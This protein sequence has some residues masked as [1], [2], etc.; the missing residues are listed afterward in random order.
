[1]EAGT[2]KGTGAWTVARM[3]AGVQVEAGEVEQLEEPWKSAAQALQSANGSGRINVLRAFCA[4]RADGDEL[5]RTVLEQDPRKKPKEKRSVGL[6]PPLPAAASLP[7]GAGAGAGMWLDEYTRYAKA[8]SPLTPELFHEAGGLW[9]VSLAVARR[10]VLHMSHK[11]VFPNVAILQVAPTTLY[12]KS[13]GLGVPRFI[14]GAVMPYLLLPGE[15]TP[16]AMVEELAGKT[17]TVL[18]GLDIEEWQKGQAYAGQRGIVL[19]EASSLFAGLGKDYQV[20]MGETL[21]RLYD[22]DPHIARQTRG[23][24]RATVRNAYWTFLGATTPWHL[25]KADC[26]SLWHTGI[27]ARF[28]LLTPDQG[29]SWHLPSRMRTEVPSGLVERIS[30]LVGVELPESKHLDP[31][32]PISV[33][34]GEGVFDAFSRYLKATMHDLLAP[35][36]AVDSR[37]W[38]V[39]GR[40]AEQALKVGILLTALDWD[41]NGAPVIGM[42]HWARAQQFCEMCRASAHRLPGMLTE[43]SQNEI[44]TKV[45]MWLSETEEW[46]TCRDVYRALNLTSST[47]K[48]TLMDLC[49]AA[50]VETKEKGRATYYRCVKEE[51]GEDS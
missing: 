1:M 11:D 16:E 29:P 23:S 51:M 2:L 42:R 36:S 43:S 9:L 30:T 50:L 31:A 33:G 28:V 38:G 19:D 48:T 40:L 32:Q 27:W 49:E 22:C 12:A 15:M 45:L 44:E 6:V 20:G 4:E 5:L 47:A 26:E 21:L 41:G 34:L 24:G 8:V 25:K 13:T 10:L 35:P 46:A 7:V 37:L 17:P 3:V 39:Y 14:A 18:E